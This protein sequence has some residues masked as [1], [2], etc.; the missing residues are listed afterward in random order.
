M[1][2][3]AMALVLVALAQTAPVHPTQGPLDTPAPP[4]TSPTAWSCTVETLSTGKDCVFESTAEPAATPGAQEQENFKFVHELVQTACE[5]A[6]KRTER[7]PAD[8]KLAAICV[9][10][11]KPATAACG[12]A[13]ERPLVDAAGRFA[14]SARSCYLQ[15]ADALRHTTVMAQVS[16]ACCRCMAAQKCAGTSD[17]CYSD[18][19]RAEPSS[20]EQACM[21]HACSDVC[22]GINFTPQLSASPAPG[23]DDS[24]V[25]VKARRRIHGN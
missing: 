9:K 17:A 15:L 12:I 25:S 16:G 23:S 24:T 7:E 13:G 18:L 11:A 19:A 14:P 4:D 22:S 8:P 3:P 1:I 2:Q 5:R 21:D 20:A 6:S 10:Q